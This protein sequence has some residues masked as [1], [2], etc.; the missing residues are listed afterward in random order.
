M[1]EFIGRVT[2]V[3][4]PQITACLDAEAGSAI[5]VGAIIRVRNGDRDAVATVIAVQTGAA[6]GDGNVIIADTMGELVR[7]VDG[8]TRFVRGLSG[9]PPA[10]AGVLSV[11]NAELD[12]IYVPPGGASI[13]VG[14]LH[15]DRQRPAFLAL[16]QLLAKHFAV[17]GST[18]SGKSCAVTLIV[19][20]VLADFPNAHIV[21]LDP[22]NE[23][24]AA[25]GERAEVIDVDNLLLPFWLFD[26]EEAVRVLVRGGTAQEQE[27]QAIILKDAMTRARRHYAGEGPA[28]AS[29]TV[30]TPVPFR[31]SDLLRFI[32]EGM[33][34][35]EKPDNSIPYLRLR[36]RLESLRDDRRFA[37]MFSERFVTRDALPQFVGRLL[38][39][40]CGGQAAGR[41]RPFRPARRGCRCRGVAVVSRDV[42]FHPVVASRRGTA[43]PG[44]VRGGAPLS[45][46]GR[47]PRFCRGG[48]RPHADRQGGPQIWD[49]AGPSVATAVGIGSGCA[50]A[51][52]YGH[53]AAAVQRSGPAPRRGSPPRHCAW[54]ANLAPGAQYR[55]RNPRRRGGVAADADS[56][57]RFARGPSPAV[58]R[59]RILAAVATPGR[60]RGNGRRGSA[61]VAFTDPIARPFLARASR[62]VRIRDER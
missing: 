32:Y 56:I 27:A 47:R 2:A 39:I 33:G 4:G 31:L 62:R 43:G 51:M 55:R 53:C 48:A 52:Q 61:S 5:G 25:F 37:F 9:H 16:D 40:P 13:R 34:R 21:L 8:R 1:V 36:T 7:G 17:L 50:V 6:L 24:A 57:R 23:Y 45:P 35:L 42:R 29:V 41:S 10:G 20:A 54:F 60:R 11:T 22:H 18:G 58:Q 3:R 19:S 59:R 15:H 30:D 38:R 46:G 14:S 26:F 12:A 28:A 44:G 49:F